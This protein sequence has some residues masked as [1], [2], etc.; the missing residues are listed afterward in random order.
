MRRPRPKQKSEVGDRE[1]PENSGEL[2]WARGRYEILSEP[3]GMWGEKWY[4]IPRRTAQLFGD[5]DPPPS[6]WEFEKTEF[7]TRPPGLYGSGDEDPWG[8]PRGTRVNVFRIS[9]PSAGL[10]VPV[11]GSSAEPYRPM[12]IA[13]DILL[14]VQRTR[15]EDVKALLRFVNR[16]GLLGVGIPGAP[17]FGTD[18]VAISSEWVA[19]LRQWVETLHALKGGREKETTWAEFAKILNEHLGG[20]HPSVSI[21]DRGVQRTFR[22]VRLLDV[23]CFEL[24]DQATEGKR[25]RRCPE[26]RALFIP[27]RANQEYCTRLCANRPTV[28]KWKREQRRKQ[29]MGQKINRED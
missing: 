16:W 22:A 18:G 12:N 20:V 2:L 15:P 5:A 21:T 6:A 13:A 25:L 9:W 4:A 11:E 23:L 14:D 29:R 3:K 28:R 8:R 27:R 19:R 7:R 24:W 1:D 10:L 26:C 17:D